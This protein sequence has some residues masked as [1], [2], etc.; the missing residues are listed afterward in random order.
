MKTAKAE[1]VAQGRTFD[2]MVENFEL[3]PRHN[4]VAAVRE[5][6]S[7]QVKALSRVNN[8]RFIRDISLQWLIIIAAIGGAIWNGHLLAFVVAIIVIATRQHALG[9]L[10]HDGTHYRLL[11]NRMLNN[12]VSDLF[13]ALPVGMLTSRYQYEH[14][15]HHR[16]LNTDRDPYW[17]EFEKDSDWHWPKRK[18]E[19]ITVFIRDLLGINM[20]AMAPVL[21]RWS[22]WA[23]H[24]SQKDAPPALTLGERLRVYGLYGA[25]AV[26]LTLSHG[27]IYFLVL[28]MLPLSTLVIAFIRIRTVGE[29]LAIAN[30][31]EL[32]AS[33]HTDAT[34][35]ER[36]TICP[37]NIN[38][39]LDHHLFPSVP[40]YNLPQLHKVLLK[41]D[42]YRSHA[43][44]YDTY[45]G[46][47]RSVLHDMIRVSLSP[48][49]P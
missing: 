26:G 41:N 3:A 44:L 8:L 48:S 37:F 25:L 49:N 33:R 38:Y 29:H 17:L 4:S 2:D 1:N 15:L 13:C 42:E 11:T 31:T 24:F 5:G 32:N 47:G 12:A 6:A 36:W 23:N 9:I 34:L 21:Y 30:E 20:R 28:W 35:L 27:W 10:M 43:L 22:P 40:Y 16:Y 14:R 7:E 39:H 46:P 19:A 45:L 18:L